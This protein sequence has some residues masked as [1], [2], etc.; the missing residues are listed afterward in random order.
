MVHK[1]QQSTQSGCLWPFSGNCQLWVH[2]CHLKDC[3]ILDLSLWACSVDTQK[4]GLQKYNI[5]LSIK[6]VIVLYSAAT[7]QLTSLQTFS[8]LNKSSLLRK[9]K[10]N[11]LLQIPCTVGTFWLVSFTRWRKNSEKER[12]N[13]LRGSKSAVCCTVGLCRVKTSLHAPYPTPHTFPSEIYIP[14]FS[15]RLNSSFIT[16]PIFYVNSGK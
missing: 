8:I 14:G 6:F 15:S 3:T 12:T 4:L 11:T 10:Q 9:I 1:I 16:T 13:M 2:R 7:H 5:N